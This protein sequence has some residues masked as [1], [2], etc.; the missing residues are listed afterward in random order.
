MIYVFPT[1]SRR[2]IDSYYNNSDYFSNYE[3]KRWKEWNVRHH[4]LRKLDILDRYHPMRGRLLDVGCADG[5]FLSLAK[6]NGWEVS[7]VEINSFAVPKTGRGADRLDIRIGTLEE[8][9]FSDGY[10]DVVTLIHNIEHYPEPFE[11]LRKVHSLLKPGGFIYVAVPNLDERTRR[12]ISV[13]PL[14]ERRRQKLLKLAGGIC[15]P[16]HLVTFSRDTLNR[17]LRECGFSPREWIYVNR[18]RPYFMD[19]FPVWLAVQALSAVNIFLRSGL[20]I[21]VLAQK[22]A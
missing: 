17:S 10:F 15:P 16:D 6:K 19:P 18:I 12:F 22:E 4:F 2:E 20:H 13:L 7:G 5:L 8:S 3:D 9:G 1:P 11:M 21:E 14:P